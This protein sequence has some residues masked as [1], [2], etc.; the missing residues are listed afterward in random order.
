[1]TFKYILA[2]VI[3]IVAEAA[4]AA[5]A[6]VAD[7]CKAYQ[8]GSKQCYTHTVTVPEAHCPYTLCPKIV[9]Q[10]RAEWLMDFKVVEVPC[11]NKCCPTTATKTI[12]TAC[13]SCPSACTPIYTQTQYA[14]PTTCGHNLAAIATGSAADR[15]VN[16]VHGESLSDITFVIG[17]RLAAE[18]EYGHQ[19]E[20]GNEPDEPEDPKAK[21]E[22][23]ADHHRPKPFPPLRPPPH[24]H[25][26]PPNQPGIVVTN[27]KPV[28]TTPTWAPNLPTMVTLTHAT[29]A[30]RGRVA[31][32]MG[33]MET[34]SLALE[35]RYADTDHADVPPPDGTN[36]PAH[37]LTHH[38][39][40]GE[41]P[42]PK[43][44]Y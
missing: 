30:S 41:P 20:D 28:F 31:A 15:M 5:P 40:H 9:N 36:V 24:H 26:P 25:K 22:G 37:P 34:G 4:I 17:K 33:A 10:C 23:D 12:S 14:Y 21:E 43:I 13:Q 7:T 1:M 35:E 11:Q 8:D 38:P 6:D 18:N 32:A 19:F 27:S 42:L 39:T 44:Q 29:H 16:A 3:A 2:V